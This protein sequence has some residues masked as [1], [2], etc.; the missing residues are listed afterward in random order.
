MARHVCITGSTRGLG[1]ALVLWFY[2]AGWHVSGCGRSAEAVQG[3]EADREPERVCFRS[4]DV[5]DDAAV[6]SF[7]DAVDEHLGTPD[8]LVN[9]A[10]LINATRPLWEVPA[11]EFDAVVDV[12]VK[13]VAN[14][15]RHFA[16]RMIERGS[17]VMVNLS[18]G[19]GRSTS[20]QVAPYCAT[21][22]AIEGLSQAMASEL[23][24]GVAVAAMNPGIID[25][26][27]LRTAFGEG[28]SSHEDAATWA[29]TAGPYLAGLGPE[30]NGRQ[31]SV[32]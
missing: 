24:R 9:N 32:S 14:V 8:L 6:A 13:G 15:L 29:E 3:L 31:L 1:Q 21:K 17:G 30:V 10:G 28:A 7:A 4:V 11:D 23:P 2:Q 26:D 22:W 12:N 20:P 25:T 18:S 27:M 16:P 19:W 5:R